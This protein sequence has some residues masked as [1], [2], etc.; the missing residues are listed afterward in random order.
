MKANRVLFVGNNISNPG[1]GERSLLQIAR[2]AEENLDCQTETLFIDSE[3]VENSEY[4]VFSFLPKFITKIGTYEI[5]MLS[6][7]L[8]PKIQE[9]ELKRYLESYNPDLVIAQTQSSYIFTKLCKEADVP[10]KVLIRADELLYDDFFHGKNLL[11]KSLNF[12]PAVINSRFADYVFENSDEVVANSNYTLSKYLKQYSGIDE[13]TSVMYPM[14]KASE[15]RVSERGEKILHI[16]PIEAKGIDITLDVA[17]KMPEKDF[18]IAGNR[19]KKEVM[20]RIRSMPNVE[21]LGFVEDMREVYKKSKIVL[22]PSRREAFG[23]ICVEA[24]YSGIPV[25]TSGIGGLSESMGF[26]QLRVSK[27]KPENYISKIN[28]VESDYDAYSEMARKNA[29]NLFESSRRSLEEL[30]EI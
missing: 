21:F 13:K 18:L 14:A 7:F 27:N 26:K 28:E 2:Y 11:T 8:T 17:E 30:L 9:G 23:R 16:N 1:G 12:V 6:R 22:F 5:R 4:E 29:E 10:I 20:D 25:I 3:E 19:G 24:G 15:Y